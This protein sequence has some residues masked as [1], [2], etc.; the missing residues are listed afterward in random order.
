M[1]RTMYPPDFYH[2]PSNCIKCTADFAEN[3]P[4]Q[5]I[6]LRGDLR[7]ECRVCGWFEYVKTADAIDNRSKKLAN[8]EVYDG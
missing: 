1:D 2:L 5:R 7:R 6:A 3:K 4:I 8:K